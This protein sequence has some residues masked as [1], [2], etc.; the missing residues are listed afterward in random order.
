[1]KQIINSKKY[2]TKT[3]KLIG[4][5]SYGNN[6]DLKSWSEQLFRKKTG[7]FFLYGRGGGM[8]KYAEEFSPKQFSE[9]EK[10]IPL[11]LEDAKKWAEKY[12][13]VGKYEEIFSVVEE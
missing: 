11:T 6:S 8:S 13:S 2:D 3:A 10:I 9:G 12:L 7:E 1:M 5:W 4:E